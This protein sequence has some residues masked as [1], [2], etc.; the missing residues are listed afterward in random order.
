MRYVT[1]Q[2][3]RNIDEQV[4][5]T[6]FR[7]P[8]GPASD[9]LIRVAAQGVVNQ[10]L[11]FCDPAAARPPVY[12]VFGTGNNGADARYAGR[13]LAGH[14]FPV[15]FLAAMDAEAL[16]GVV[17]TF[18]EAGP[19]VSVEACASPHAWTAQPTVL[20]PPGAIII[21]GI[22]GTGLT[23]APREPAASAI[24]WINRH[25]GRAH[26]VSVD[27]PSGLNAD[28]GTAPGA[29]VVAD[30]T[31][32]MGLPKKGFSNP[33]ALRWT[34]SVDVHDLAMTDALRLGDPES[35]REAFVS[36]VDVSS[37]IAPR[38][39]DSHKGDYGH[40]CVIGGAPGYSGAPTLAALGALRAGAGLVSVMTPAAHA[41][42]VSAA[43]PEAMVYALKTPVVSAFSLELTRFDFSDKVLV[44]GPGLSCDPI[45][46]EAVAWILGCRRPGGVI[47]DADALNVLADDVAALVAYDGPKVITP[48]PGEAA[49][50][51]GVQPADVQADRAA[52]VR[53]LVERTGA[54]V[55]LKGA[56]TLVSAPGRGVWLVPCVN[57]GLAR[58]GMGDVLAGVVG[59]LLARGVPAFEAASAAAWLH[60][61][62][63]DTVAWRRGRES[64]LPRDVADA[65]WFGFA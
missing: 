58:G 14:G 36:G 27:V 55:V 40:V 37:W 23:Q 28:T 7:F 54:T 47:L 45:A 39:W 20:V 10:V 2:E 8:D 3:M 53:R 11:A 64:L 46:R 32:C 50:L 51:L 13:T 5:A 43:L 52:A 38:A 35:D 16:T 12:V 19:C 62:A 4:R 21:D 26:I 65:L 30:F 31:V 59:A 25:R 22:L 48:H 49:R 1:V 29:V 61:R 44:I 17:R 15:S 63:A 56:G 34:G 41:A 60:G 42:S 6:T 9:D 33:S 57:P 18:P 24:R